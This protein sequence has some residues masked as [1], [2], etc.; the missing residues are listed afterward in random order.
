MMHQHPKVGLPKLV[1]CYKGEYLPVSVKW[2][3]IRLSAVR[4][5]DFLMGVYFLWEVVFHVRNDIYIILIH[6][7]ICPGFVGHWQIGYQTQFLI[8]LPKHSTKYLVQTFGNMWLGYW[9]KP[10]TL[11]WHNTDIRTSWTW[12]TIKLINWR[13]ESVE[14]WHMVC[15]FSRRKLYFF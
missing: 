4:N 14:A 12:Y 7:W 1:K 11:L 8:Y 6:L 15:F 10:S 2:H 9:Q 3:E 13:G 5:C